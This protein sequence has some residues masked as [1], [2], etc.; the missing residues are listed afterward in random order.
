[1]TAD[2]V[3]AVEREEQR[4]EAH[5]ASLKKELGLGDLVLQQI[6]FVVDGLFREVADS[7]SPLPI[8]ARSE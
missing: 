5:S 7:L 8:P 4:V 6:V 1:M 3:T 2:A